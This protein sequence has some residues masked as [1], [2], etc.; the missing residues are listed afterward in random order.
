M[1]ETEIPV[2]HPVNIGIGIGLDFFQIL[3]SKLELKNSRKISK[4]LVQ[5]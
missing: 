2:S 3:E 4:N 1:V 5:D